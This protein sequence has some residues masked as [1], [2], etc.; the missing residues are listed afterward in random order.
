MQGCPPLRYS[1]TAVL[2]ECQNRA[3]TIEQPRGLELPSP[4][5]KTSCFEDKHC[6]EERAEVF[7]KSAG[8]KSARLP[9]KL[10]ALARAARTRLG[11]MKQ[12]SSHVS[13]NTWQVRGN[14]NDY[15]RIHT[16]TCA[17]T[18]TSPYHPASRGP[19]YLKGSA[20][21]GKDRRQLAEGVI[22][23]LADLGTRGL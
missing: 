7:L 19:G 15:L 18:Y 21:P 14:L 11:D 8:P 6:T 17:N 12:Q 4:N 23:L 22:H 1:W 10:C 16:C 9:T 13:R 3:T 2:T 5:S 20:I